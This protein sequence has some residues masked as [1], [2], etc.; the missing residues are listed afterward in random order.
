MFEE[1]IFSSREM[2]FASCSLYAKFNVS[3]FHNG[4]LNPLIKIILSFNK[5][6]NVFNAINIAK[7]PL[8]LIV[9]FERIF[10]HVSI[11]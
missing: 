9:A 3:L 2:N 4:F 1:Q 11:K 6:S 5:I 7:P 10:I 8:F